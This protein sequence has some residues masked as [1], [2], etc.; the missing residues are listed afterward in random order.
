MLFADLSLSL[1]GYVAGPDPSLEEPLGKGGE[2][3]HEWA[4]AAAAWRER[5]GRE[6]GE[7]GRDSELIREQVDATGAVIMGR[8]MFSGGEGGWDDDPRARGWWGGDP[9]VPLPVVVL[10]HPRPRGGCWSTPPGR[11]S[12]SRW[13]AGRRSTSSP[14]APRPRSSRP[15][16]R[17][18]AR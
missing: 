1:D 18:G 15:G 14:T 6:G 10:T 7:G 13:R 11:G 17:P 5:H 8:R 4:F 3:L 16:P 2:Q 12:R 9:A